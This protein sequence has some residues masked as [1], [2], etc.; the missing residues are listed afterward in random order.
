MFERCGAGDGGG[1]GGG[2][3]EAERERKNL[4]DFTAFRLRRRRKGEKNNI[5]TRVT[6]REID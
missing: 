1:G 4:R 6:W 3:E 5:I 2:R